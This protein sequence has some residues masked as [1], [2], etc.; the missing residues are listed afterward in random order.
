[1]SI[2]DN[3][4]YLMAPPESRRLD[5]FASEYEA[6]KSAKTQKEIAEADRQFA[7]DQ[8]EKQR[9]YDLPINQRAR[10]EEA[11]FNPYFSQIS[12]G[13]FTPLTNSSLASA[14]KPVSQNKTLRE[15]AEG[16][17]EDIAS[18]LSLV[19]NTISAVGQMQDFNIQRTLLK[20]ELEMSN[21]DKLISQFD[22]ENYGKEKAM[23]NVNDV[24]SWATKI[25][26]T[27]FSGNRT[28]YRRSRGPKK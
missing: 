21:N 17:I 19:S 26:S 7:L 15:Q 16:S 13:E 24:V 20:N 12:S 23:E 1:M 11:G 22:A 5:E 3:L 28:Y 4:I 8:L 27:I 10:L 9:V 14:A 18:I 2:L 25:L 6:N